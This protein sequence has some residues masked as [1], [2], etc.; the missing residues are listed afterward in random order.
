MSAKNKKKG[1]AILGKGA[2]TFP[3]TGNTVQEGGITKKG[4]YILGS[5][6]IIL[7][8]GYLSLSKAAPDGRD[9]WANLAAI[10]LTAGYLMIPFGI[11]ARRPESPLKPLRL[12]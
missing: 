12:L 7:T 11:M 9:L 4:G 6:A 8:A 5:A 2:K 3:E 10:L 1:S